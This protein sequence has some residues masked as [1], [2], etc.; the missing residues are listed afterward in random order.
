MKPASPATQP[1]GNAKAGVSKT[2]ETARPASP[3]GV[4][5]EAALD[6]LQGVAGPTEK[7]VLAAL[8]R[9]LELKADAPLKSARSVAEDLMKR[10]RQFDR[11]IGAARRRRG[12]ARRG[13]RSALLMRWPELTNALHPKTTLILRDEGDAVVK[14]IEAAPQ[15]KEM[16]RAEADVDRIDTEKMN[17][18]RKWAKAQR[19]IR[20]A[21]NVALASNLSSVATPEVVAKYK[22]IVAA[23]AGTLGS[24]A[25]KRE[26]ARE[27][28]VAPR[29]AEE[30]RVETVGCDP[31]IR[32]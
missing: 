18:D 28:A 25:P 24:A 26:D 31:L 1:A 3:A 30:K 20:V 32:Q 8:A 6:V 21:E 27:E 12:D 5:V 23:E 11:D 22:A 9:Q 19:F 4:D 17:L 14:L 10:Q 2:T 13:L 7:A 16:E 29:S 15:F